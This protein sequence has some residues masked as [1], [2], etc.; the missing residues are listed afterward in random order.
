MAGG[1]LEHE[2]VWIRHRLSKLDDERDKLVARLEELRG[3]PPPS[4]DGPQ[5]M[6]DDVIECHLRGD[7]SI[8]PGTRGQGFVPGVYPLLF[9][10]TCL[11]VDA[12]GE[13]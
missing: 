2:I 10:D 11:A 13:D 1:T 7:D 8:R 5:R 3:F 9:D 6:S 12:D 4:P